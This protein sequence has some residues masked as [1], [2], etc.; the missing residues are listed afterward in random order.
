[1][2]N[3][4]NVR[5]DE[6]GPVENLPEEYFGSVPKT[7][8]T[9]DMKFKVMRR[10][11]GMIERFFAEGG[12]VAVYDANNSNE[13]HRNEVREWFA[14]GEV[15]T[16]FIESLCNDEEMVERNIRS[17]Y[18]YSPDVRCFASPSTLDGICLT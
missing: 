16:I 2:F 4:A 14:D 13:K 10:I 17:I 7:Q 11:K 15:Q 6:L 5:R 3:L 8:E 18:Q 12:Q 1:M 9:R